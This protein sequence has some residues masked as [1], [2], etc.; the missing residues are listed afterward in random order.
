MNHVATAPFVDRTEVATTCDT[1]D[2]VR[3]RAASSME[4]CATRRTSEVIEHL[5]SDTR[6]VLEE[7]Q[8]VA[9]T[10]GEKGAENYADNCQ[11][12]VEFW[13]NL[14]SARTWPQATSIQK[15]Y[16]ED[17]S[18]VWL[19]QSS[20]MTGLLGKFAMLPCVSMSGV[21]SRTMQQLTALSRST[22]SH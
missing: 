17:Q 15:K 13:S 10:I 5:T 21:A 9:S 1:P 12:I 2:R 7:L 8:T 19:R 22:T 11:S 18:K 14:G 3:E 4:V 20:E 6:N 16:W